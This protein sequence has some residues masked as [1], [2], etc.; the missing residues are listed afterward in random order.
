MYTICCVSKL[1]TNEITIAAHTNKDRT[2][3]CADYVRLYLLLHD[4]DDRQM[5]IPDTQRA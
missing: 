3:N 1:S 5:S 4:T 2:W